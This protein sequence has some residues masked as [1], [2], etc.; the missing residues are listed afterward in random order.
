MEQQEQELIKRLIELEK[1]F[2]ALEKALE[3]GSHPWGMLKAS[4]VVGGVIGEKLS[5]L[6]ITSE[7]L[8]DLYQDCP[9]V[10]AAVA[11]KVSLMSQSYENPLA[12]E[13]CLEKTGNGNYWVIGTEA[14]NFWLVPKDTIKINAQMMKT[15]ESLFKCEGYQA[16]QTKEFTLIQAA[17]V[18]RSPDGEQWVL[19]ELG[20]LDFRDR[21]VGSQLREE[22]T[23]MREERLQI[24][25]QLKQLNQDFWYFKHELGQLIEMRP[26]E[27][28]SLQEQLMIATQERDELKMK[29]EELQQQLMIVSKERLKLERKVEQLFELMS[30]SQPIPSQELE[31]EQEEQESEPSEDLSKKWKR[32]ELVQTLEKHTDSVRTLAVGC[33]KESEETHRIIASGGYDNTIRL[34]N[35]QT[36]ELIETVSVAA[37]VNKLAISPIAPILVSGSDLRYLQVW[38]LLKDETKFL[39]RH[40]DRILAVVI[41]PDG[42]T[43]ASGGA[44]KKLNI[45]NLPS[46]EFRQTLTEEDSAICCL[47]ISSDGKILVSSNGNNTI[48]RWNLETGKLEKSL[49]T[50]MGL[51]W[52]LAISPAE[53]ILACG[54]RD[55]LVKVLNLTTGEMLHQL[56]GHSKE[57]YAVAFS[58]DGQTL[59][60]GSFDNTVKLWRVK[61][62]ELLCTLTGHQSDV[63]GVAFSPD[64]RFLVSG[65]RDKLIKIWKPMF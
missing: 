43:L 19:E 64:G 32:V 44:D 15:V 46:G 62:G 8:V 6:N 27:V 7:Q 28:D 9:Q 11:I 18:S 49:G 53:N 41:S 61:T 58:P 25:F 2:Q 40:S 50:Y 10:L 59:A 21:S 30:K 55:R 17:Q 1:K 26:G 42:K 14:E 35:W 29:V 3:E 34:W 48:K 12:G 39:K 20:I 16:S 65:G 63:Y 51:I 38:D 47:A 33:W 13:I 22:L 4:R 24:G 37:R 31:I 5:M 36:G 60:S 56:R 23:Q 54:C 45:W 57:V 52:D